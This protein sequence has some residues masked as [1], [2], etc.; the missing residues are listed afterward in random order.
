MT[1]IS[2]APMT[3]ADYA[4]IS[5]E[6]L[7]SKVV[8][9]LVDNGS[10]MARDIPFFE[11]P[12]LIAAGVRWEK[13]L[14]TPH[15][16]SLNEQPSSTTGTPTPYQE[17]AFILRDNIDTDRRLVMDKNNIVDPRGVRIDAYLKAQAYDFNDKFLN[18]DHITGDAKAFL[19]LK[20][21]LNNTIGCRSEQLIDAGA[22]D[23]SSAGMTAATA[24]LFV[25]FLE[26]A[27]SYCDLSSGG[28]AGR[29]YM[30]ETLLRRFRRG[31]RLMGTSGGLTITQDQYDRTVETFHGVPIYDIGRK[32]DQSTLIIPSVET[33][34]GASSGGN[35]TSCYVCN[36]GPEH[37][38]GWQFE[39]IKVTDLGLLNDGVNMRTNI[40]W[41]GGIMNDNLRSFA[42]VF[43]IKLA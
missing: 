10:V 41:A 19:G 31:L 26:Q 9:S 14:P 43:D 17:Q 15:W 2:T 42:R 32:I 38:Y 22:V 37:L 36:F 34:A 40:D 35:S 27:L 30:N 23:M 8:S 21:R 13:G 11:S 33:S 6:P 1:N 20:F 4:I 18:N 24:N 39:P 3:L 7:V 28:M 5:H 29:I 25:E 16:A 12:Q